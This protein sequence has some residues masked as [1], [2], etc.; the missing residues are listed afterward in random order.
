MSELKHAQAVPFLLWK[1]FM[2]DEELEAKFEGDLRF[3]NYY[4]DVLRKQFDSVQ[5]FVTKE[6]GDNTTRLITSG[7]GDYYARVGAVRQWVGREE[8]LF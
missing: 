3:L 2:N 8:R 1:R 6:N 4:A 7:R 5:I